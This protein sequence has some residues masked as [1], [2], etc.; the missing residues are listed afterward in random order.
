MISINLTE[1]ELITGLIFCIVIS[2]FFN[3]LE[4]FSTK[5]KDALTKVEVFI[6]TKKL[7]IKDE[8]LVQ[9]LDENGNNKINLSNMN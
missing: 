2:F 5:V 8:I 6:P 3:P 4:S 7:Q 9:M 1:H